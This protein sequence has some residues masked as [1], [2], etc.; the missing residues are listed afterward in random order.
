[1]KDASR[2]TGETALSEIDRHDPIKAAIERKRKPELPQWPRERKFKGKC[3]K[4]NREGHRASDCPYV[5]EGTPCEI[6]HMY[7]HKTEDCFEDPK[8]GGNVLV[9]GS[10]S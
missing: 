3:F 8:I 4:C 9:I 2:P 10:P 7:G 1:M 5:S 6:C